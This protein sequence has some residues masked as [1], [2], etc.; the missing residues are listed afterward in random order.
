MANAP[1]DSR[2]ARCDEWL[3]SV[4]SALEARDLDRATACACNALADGIEH[5]MFLNLRA[6]RLE[7][8]GRDNEALNDLVRAV[9]LD[10]TD[11]QA[12]NAIGLSFFRHGRL[13]DAANA[14][15]A[16][17]VSA[18][19]FSHAHFNLGWALEESG[20]LNGAESA[21]VRAHETE[22]DAP[23]PLGKRALLA[24]RRG[25]FKDAEDF[26]LAA[27]ERDGD[28]PTAALALAGVEIERKQFEAA[29]RRLR[30]LIARPRIA[31]L[32][33]ANAH[34]MLGD[35]L[36][37]AGR[38]RE[39]FR[40]YLA[41]NGEFHRAHV[42]QFAGANRQTVPQ[43][44]AA[45]TAYF[46]RAAPWPK[47]PSKN[48]ISRRHVFIVGFPRSGTTLIENILAG[49]PRTATS[50][51]TDGLASGVQDFLRD[52]STLDR[53]A[54]ADDA[55][56]EPHR[57]FYWTAMEKRGASDATRNFIDKSPY[58]AIKLPLIARLFPE[59]R[60][61]FVARDPRDVALGCF[62]QRFR[63]NPSNFELLTLEGAARFYAAT[64]RLFELYRAKLPLD[65]CE[66][67]LEDVIGNFEVSVGQLCAFTGLAWSEDMRNFAELARDRAIATPSANQVARG[68]DP[69]ARGQ[70]RLYAAE[71]ESVMPILAP[72][73][74][75]FGYS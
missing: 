65:V 43:Y 45:L 30:D 20:D 36:H 37:A 35:A 7:S 75:R 67:R 11:A 27:L 17:T 57:R 2:Q 73:I 42:E 31:Q 63:M 62:R 23:S 39:A 5:P 26:A 71:L 70:W 50:D 16:A 4:K 32:D 47:T 9:E 28:N 58:N 72:W 12:Q 15:R 51:E 49:A 55:T 46:E 44:L 34:G 18:P 52:A 66:V 3:A 1:K 8:E 54:G 6:Y 21:Y 48:D 60:I 40:A 13:A 22:P 19:S 38:P 61:I 64:M 33:R 10:P 74:E 69:S 53:L 59:A 29:E 41:C 56:L 24:A 14:F 68:L 25:R